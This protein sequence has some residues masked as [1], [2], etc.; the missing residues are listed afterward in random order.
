[1]CFV[2]VCVF[3]VFPCVFATENDEEIPNCLSILSLE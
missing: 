1:V 2:C 3:F